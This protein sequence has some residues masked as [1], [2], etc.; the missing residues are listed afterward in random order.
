[1]NEGCPIAPSTE[2]LK[3]R[4]RQDVCQGRNFRR[5]Q[6]E[7]CLPLPGKP[8]RMLQGLQ[9]FQGASQIVC[10]IPRR[11]RSIEGKPEA[12]ANCPQQPNY[13]QDKQTPALA[14]PMLLCHCDSWILGCRSEERV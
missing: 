8:L 14:V 7:V 9:V 13:A 6:P 5:K 12:I 2:N 11:D 4:N 3:K 10:L 1:M